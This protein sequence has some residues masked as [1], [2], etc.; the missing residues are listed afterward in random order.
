VLENGQWCVD[1]EVVKDNVRV[2]FRSRWTMS[3]LTPSLGKITRCW[4]VIFFEEIKEAVWNCD[5]SKSLG[6]IF[7]SLNLVGTSLKRMCWR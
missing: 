6:L 7:V 3:D 4:L 2:F 1:K 5:S